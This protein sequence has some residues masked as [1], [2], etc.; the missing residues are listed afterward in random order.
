MTGSRD[1]AAITRN[2][3]FRVRG[4][5]VEDLEI[6]SSMLQDAV[7][8]ISETV[9]DPASGRFIL[10]TQRFRWELTGGETGTDATDQC[11]ERVLC[12][13]R[14]QSVRAV[15][16]H[17]IDL[18][19]R[20]QML[21]LLSIHLGDG[22]V[23]LAFAGKKTIRLSVTDFDCRAEDIGEPWPTTFFPNHSDEAP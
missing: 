6:V 5:T 14:F 22:R 9:F 17:G 2:R 3:S 7:V 20:G 10:M 1:I 19:D 23:D 8:P 15:R 21:E 13:L 11:Y 16:S 18:S 4:E 12:A